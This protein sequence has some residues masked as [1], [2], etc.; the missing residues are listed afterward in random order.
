MTLQSLSQ[1][2]TSLLQTVEALFCIFQLLNVKQESIEYQ[3]LVFGLTRQGIEP[4]STVSV[5]NA[6]FV[7]GMSKFV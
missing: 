4:E 3:L 2:A 6:H 5:A 1:T 7:S